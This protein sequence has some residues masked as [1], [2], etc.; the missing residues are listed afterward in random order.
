MSANFEAIIREAK[1]VALE[2]AA[3]AIVTNDP[4]DFWNFHLPEGLGF[5][6]AMSHWL[7]AHAKA[8]RKAT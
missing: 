7:K 4:L 6:E 5:Q 3:A 1:A 2:E 8:A